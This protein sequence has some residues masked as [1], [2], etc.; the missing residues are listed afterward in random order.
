MA[1]VAIPVAKDRRPRYHAVTYPAILIESDIYGGWDPNDCPS[2]MILALD[3]KRF[4]MIEQQLYH[5][6]IARCNG[7]SHDIS[8]AMVAIPVVSWRISLSRRDLSRN[9]Y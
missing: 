1:M 8:M 3:I 9:P 2:S 7:Q 4:A 5:S 6:D